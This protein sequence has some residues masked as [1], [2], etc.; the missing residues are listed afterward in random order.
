M[1]SFWLKNEKAFLRYI[2]IPGGE[3]ALV[4][5]HGLGTSAIADFSET[6]ADSRFRDYRCLAIDFLG[7]GFSDKPNEFEY[8]LY[9]HAD[10][11][12]ELLDNLQ[13]KGAIVAGHSMGGTVAIALAQKRA[14]LV[15]RL[16]IMEPNLDPGVG[17]LSKTIALQTESDFITVG[18]EKLEM[19]IRLSA[20]NNPSDAIYL[21]TFMIADSIALHRS[22]GGLLEGTDPPQRE[23]LAAMPIPRAYIVG[24]QNINEIPLK[25][26]QALGLAIVVVPNAG[27]SMMHENPEGFRA[28]LLKAIIL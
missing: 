20:H 21:G 24:E 3:P 5:L 18:R 15:S 28:A 10:V 9:D 26:L 11:V 23:V 27:H 16:I 22:A 13:I 19:A 8:G 7:F 1:K 12:A 6:A 4:F 2:D 14:N 17:T 25:E